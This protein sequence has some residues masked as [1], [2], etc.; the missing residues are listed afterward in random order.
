MKIFITDDYNSVEELS[1]AL[2][3]ILELVKDG[4]TSG[5]YPTWSIED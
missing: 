1:D 4:N 3:H 2:E 5:Y